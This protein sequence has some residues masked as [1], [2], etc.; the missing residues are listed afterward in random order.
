MPSPPPP[1]T[2][3]AI[4]P[5]SAATASTHRNWSAI[6]ESVRSSSAAFPAE[7]CELQLVED[8]EVICASP[9]DVSFHAGG[10]RLGRPVLRMNGDRRHAER[11]HFESLMLKEIHDQP[12]VLRETI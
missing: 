3:K 5:S 1:P 2:S 8:D 4:S 6:G 10:R 9:A 11:G 12:R 7:L